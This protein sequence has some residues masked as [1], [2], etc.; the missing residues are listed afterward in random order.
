MGYIYRLPNDFSVS[1]GWQ[2]PV[3]VPLKKKRV[4]MMK[5][6]SIY[7]KAEHGEGIFG[8]GYIV[9]KDLQK[10][11]EIS[12]AENAG[13][14]N[15]N[16]FQLKIHLNYY[17]VYEPYV[18]IQYLRHFPSYNHR[19]TNKPCYPY[20]LYWEAGINAEIEDIFSKFWYEIEGIYKD[21]NWK[22]YIHL[23]REE[24]INKYWNDKLPRETG[25]CKLCGR[26]YDEPYFLEIHDTVNIDFEGAYVPVHI[27][28]FIVLCPNCH[29][30]QHFKMRKKK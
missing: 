10:S 26:K 6:I 23:L 4:P 28:D 2:I 9:S 14:I 7:R 16:Y 24:A 27:K 19:W 15:R 11:S 13:I 5:S 1:P 12:G 21:A 30:E 22:Y 20:T 18:Y 25:K 29:K 17:S 8:L 3:F